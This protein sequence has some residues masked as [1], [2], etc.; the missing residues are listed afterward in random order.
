VGEEVANLGP[1][2]QS[3]NP[4]FLLQVTITD[5]PA[6]TAE[7]GDDATAKVDPTDAILLLSATLAGGAFAVPTLPTVAAPDFQ[8]RD[9]IVPIGPRPDRWTDAD[10]PTIGSTGPIF[11]KIDVPPMVDPG[12]KKQEPVT[13]VPRPP[14]KL[15]IETPP[16]DVKHGKIVPDSERPS[17]GSTGPIFGRIEQGAMRH[18]P[19]E[20]QATSSAEGRP[21]PTGPAPAEVV[22][23]PAV[24][25]IEEST[26]APAVSASAQPKPDKT[27]AGE[28]G[29]KKVDLKVETV[30]EDSPT[31]R[32]ETAKKVAAKTT[33]LD[34]EDVK[35]ASA[36][37]VEPRLVDSK[38]ESTSE[39]VVDKPTLRKHDLNLVVRQITDRLELLAATRP[40][41]GVTVQ[42]QPA[43]LGSITLTVKSV[44]SNVEAHISASNDEVRTAL[45]QNRPL[46]GQLMQE[47]GLKLDSVSIAAQTA[48]TSHRQPQGQ[49]S[50]QQQQSQTTAQMRGTGIAHDPTTTQQVRQTV[51]SLDGVDLWI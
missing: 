19:F 45:E 1:N 36:K 26:V 42:L 43:R 47:R 37:T 38:V 21:I 40:K 14:I 39:A 5:K 22:P 44:G 18:K 12:D 34:G 3:P 4:D 32:S 23:E 51:R 29:S 48:T 10:Q 16:S 13:I 7:R 49:A 31:G 33:A 2:A 9:G 50:Q 41:N 11:G 28:P 20:P 35:S 46:L 17:I 25:A 8:M 24:V 27:K 15:K 6:A 30:A